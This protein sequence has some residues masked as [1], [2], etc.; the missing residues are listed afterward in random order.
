MHG[1]KV[2]IIKESP[3]SVFVDIS[4]REHCALSR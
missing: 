4:V 1:V 2:K 3:S